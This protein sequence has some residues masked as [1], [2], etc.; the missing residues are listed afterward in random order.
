MRGVAG[1]L[2]A[3]L[4]LSTAYNAH[5]LAQYT[6]YTACY[7]CVGVF[8]QGDCSVRNAASSA[9]SLL[10]ACAVRACACIRLCD[11]GWCIVDNAC[12]QVIEG[13]AVTGRCSTRNG[14]LILDVAEC[15]GHNYSNPCIG[16]T[17]C[18]ACAQD[19][20]CGAPHAHE[21]VRSACPRLMKHGCG[22]VLWL[23]PQVGAA[24]TTYANK[25]TAR[26]H[27]DPAR[28]QAPRMARG[29]S[30][31]TRVRHGAT[32]RRT[33]GRAASWRTAVRGA[34]AAAFAVTVWCSCVLACLHWWSGWCMGSDAYPLEGA[35]CVA[36]S[37]ASQ[38]AAKFTT[39]NQCSASLCT[40]PLSSQF[41][42]LCLD[43]SG[44]GVR[45]CLRTRF[46][47]C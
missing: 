3:L 35:H 44:C 22:V 46:C 2:S 6:L 26:H 28:P 43:V 39:R 25:A 20:K 12:E 47:W 38:C 41:P 37:V 31:L 18:T 40:I 21:L 24:T 29:C 14:T 7:E 33:V 11:P 8:G 36:S 9:G 42:S 17:T 27:T 34:C 4:F 1:A 5:V 15:Q 19:P 23:A 45:C 16:H 30:T 10:A 13:V 32:R